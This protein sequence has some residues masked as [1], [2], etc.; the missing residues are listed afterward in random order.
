LSSAKEFF[1]AARPLS[2]SATI[3]GRD[4]AQKIWGARRPFQATTFAAGKKLKIQAG[5]FGSHALKQLRSVMGAMHFHDG[6]RKAGDA[7]TNGTVV[8]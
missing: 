3:A 4:D 1:W 7:T 6:D 8:C 5:A 2:P